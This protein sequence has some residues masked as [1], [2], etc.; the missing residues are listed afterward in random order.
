ML[1]REIK[2][3]RFFENS[4]GNVAK[5]ANKKDAIGGYFQPE[6]LESSEFTGP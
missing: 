1:E 5:G 3:K 6:N 4:Y 2:L